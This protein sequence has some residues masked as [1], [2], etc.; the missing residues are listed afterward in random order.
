MSDTAEQ[1]EPEKLRYPASSNLPFGHG[2]KISD[3]AIEEATGTTEPTPEIETAE[4]PGEGGE[5]E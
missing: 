3:E 2:V 1:Q 4:A 5:T